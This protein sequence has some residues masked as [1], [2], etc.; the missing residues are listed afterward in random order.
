M[1]K[2]KYK[3]DINPIQEKIIK[4]VDKTPGIRYRELLR[5][6]GVANGTLSYHLKLLINSRIIKIY[7]F[8]NRITRYFS[9]NLSIREFKVIGFLRQNT[10]RKI[11][12][13][14][15]KN[16]PCNFNNIVNHTKKAPST[17]SWHLSRLKNGNIIKSYKKNDITYY[18]IKTNKLKLQNLLNKYKSSFTR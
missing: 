5:I 4:F 7:R 3:T 15:L 13:Y 18:Q 8:N 17:I 11:I 2:I 9:H 16:E 10:T 1:A 14:I 12:V 6:T